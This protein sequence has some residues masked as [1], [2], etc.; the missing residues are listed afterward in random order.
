MRYKTLPT[1]LYFVED[2]NGH[3]HGPLIK[4]KK[5]YKNRRVFL[6]EDY[7]YGTTSVGVV[8]Y[9]S[10]SFVRWREENNFIC[11]GINE[12]FRFKSGDK[13]YYKLSYINDLCG[14]RF[15]ELIITD[16]AKERDDFEGFL[17][18]CKQCLN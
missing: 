11:E 6:R 16:T 1:S 2:A 3:F 5:G 8:C 18:Q 4:P 15:D 9:D 14:K 12:K 17:S 10:L 7:L 13:V